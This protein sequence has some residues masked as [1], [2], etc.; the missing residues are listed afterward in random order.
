MYMYVCIYIY[1][2]VHI[3]IY[4]YIHT[5]VYVRSARA[6]VLVAERAEIAR[7]GFLG[8]PYL[9]PPSLLAHYVMIL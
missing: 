3:Y 6:D 9:G 1:I 7:R 5:H 2:Y 8:A 4:I